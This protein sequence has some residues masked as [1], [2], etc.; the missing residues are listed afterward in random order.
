MDVLPVE[1][2]DEGL[3]QR[4]DDGVGQIIAAMFDLLQLVEA[5][6]KFG[7]VLQNVLQQTSALRNVLRHFGEHAEEFGLPRNQADHETRGSSRNLA[8][9]LVSADPKNA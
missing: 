5:R 9:R 4:G 2:S 7:W 8:C 3:V 1:R 6:S